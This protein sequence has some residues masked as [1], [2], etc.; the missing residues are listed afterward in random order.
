M[1]TVS[2]RNR[3]LVIMSCCVTCTIITRHRAYLVLCLNITLADE[4]QLLPA[5][6]VGPPSQTVFYPCRGVQRVLCWRFKLGCGP[7]RRDSISCFICTISLHILL[8]LRSITMLKVPS[9]SWSVL[10]RH[11]QLRAKHDHTSIS[12]ARILSSA[13][14][15]NQILVHFKLSL[16]TSAMSCALT[17]L[18]DQSPWGKFPLSLASE[19]RSPCI[20]EICAVVLVECPATPAPSVG[21]HALHASLACRV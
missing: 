3:D 12:V 1:A 7:W 11:G 18:S 4:M 20:N 10:R 17:Y 8:L 19:T 6:Q 2:D 16:L 21:A 9:S 13:H 5:Q 15:A 14:M